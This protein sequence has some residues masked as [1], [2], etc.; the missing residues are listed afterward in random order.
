MF[1]SECLYQ[2]KHADD[3]AI[4]ITARL[5]HISILSAK[6]VSRMMEKSTGIENF[7]F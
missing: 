3:M 4:N 7:I 6:T 2:K 5:K 1:D